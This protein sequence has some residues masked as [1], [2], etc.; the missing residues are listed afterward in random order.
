MN[1]YIFVAPKKH[2][3]I[4][5][6]M[7]KKRTKFNHFRL[8]I[9]WTILIMLGYMVV[10][11]WTDSNYAADFEA[12]C[13]FGGIQSF[14]SYLING[15]LA[16]SMTTTQIVMGL[17]LIG[18]VVLFSKLFCGYICPIG[19]VTEWLGKLGKKLKVNI[20]IKGIPDRILRILKYA[21]LWITVYFTITSSELFCKTFDPFYAIFTG[22][23]HDVNLIYALITIGIVI[24]GSVFLKQF[25]C[26]YLCPL[27][28]L[29]NMFTYFI[30]FAAIFGG[31]AILLIAG[32]EISWLWPFT[33]SV[34]L[35]YVLEAWKLKGVF[36]PF[37][38]ITRDEDICTSCKLCDKACP[39]GIE[40][41]T[42][43]CKVK[44]I[45]CNLCA[46]CITVCPH[47]GALN[48]N[49][50]KMKWLPAVLTVVIIAGGIWFASN[51]EL[52]T[53]NEKWGSPEELELAEVLE[54][55][56][57]K[58]IKCYGSSM[59][60][61]AQMRETEGVL[62]A[63]TYV[64]NK[65]I[66][67]YFNPNV[68]SRS[69]LIESIFNPA[70]EIINPEMPETL[71]ICDLAIQKFFDSYDSFYLLKLLSSQEG[72]YA[73]ESYF[74]EPVNVKIY[75]DSGV[76]KSDQIV[77]LIESGKVSYTSGGVEQSADVFFKVAN[78]NNDKETMTKEEVVKH[79][80]T[81]YYEAYPENGE[82]SDSTAQRVVVHFKNAME[83]GIDGYYSFMGSHLF[84]DP[85]ILLFEVG[86]IDGPVAVFTIDTSL[87]NT[88][89]I[90]SLVTAD[91]LHV[92]YQDDT[93]G[94]V[95]NPFVFEPILFEADSV[96]TAEDIIPE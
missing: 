86:Y 96:K 67:V 80:M 19:T 90:I 4:L 34:V 93:E 84:S 18:A 45:D 91:S 10:R 57:L 47:E 69:E 1:D 76:V 43:P 59:G 52:P 26:K 7:A 37:L 64:K 16:C 39:Q 6:Q 23:G 62:G 95:A 79:F 77:A 83:S 33:V 88:E 35:A 9:Q 58:S 36:F 75:F 42:V 94:N 81:P 32:V 55:E 13:P 14:G 31:Y 12:Y 56:G 89:R 24:I 53:V 65:A 48:L 66:E 17:A 11:L 60:F 40:V 50:R 82:A 41:S 8:L 54:M 85:G 28:A 63:A 74:G 70:A 27:A 21:L 2:I 44:D 61:L 15:T 38:R 72:V 22:F 71:T 30:A 49:K 51:W 73:F 29:S 68:I 5:Q 3:L 78:I 92:W 25:W 46:D 87:T 20:S